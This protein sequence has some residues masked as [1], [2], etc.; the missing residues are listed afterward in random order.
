[1]FDRAQIPNNNL[2]IDCTTDN[3]SWILWMELDS[4][5]LDW[6]LQNVVKS[7]NVWVLKVKYQHIWVETETHKV[8]TVFVSLKVFNKRNGDQVLL[9]WVETNARHSLWL[10]VFLFEV[11]AWNEGHSS[12][13]GTGTS[14]LIAQHIEIV[15][16]NINDFVG[17][18]SL[19][20]AVLDTV[21]KF[22]KLFVQ[23]TLRDTL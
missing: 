11:S 13:L 20:N 23:V 10:T 15:L 14:V 2:T 6:S 17:L 7:D 4:C 1:M 21:N 12:G 19:L 16:E 22:V 9:G 8:D 5:D 18:Q 3:D